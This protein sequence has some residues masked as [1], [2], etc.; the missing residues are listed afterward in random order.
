MPGAR[1]P[2]AGG[3]AILLLNRQGHLSAPHVPLLAAVALLLGGGGAWAQHPS[4][5]GADW[6]LHALGVTTPRRLAAL[7]AE[8]RRPVTIAI[9][10]QG[11]VSQSLLEPV[12]VA[13]NTLEYRQWPEGQAPDPGTDTHDTQA[14]RVILDLTLKLNLTVRLLVYHAAESD[15]SEAQ[16]LA[17]AGAEADIVT[18]YQS[19]WGDVSSL[20]ESIRRSR[21]ALFISP[22]VEVGDTPTSACL[23]AYAAKPWAE[24]LAHFVT[25]IPLARTAPGVLLTPLSRPEQD[26]EVVNFIAPSYYASGAGGTCPSAEVAA[27]VAAYAI[28]ASRDRPSPRDVVAL[29]GETSLVDRAALTSVPEFTEAAVAAIEQQ[30]T[31]LASPPEGTPRKLDARGILN[32]WALHQALARPALEGRTAA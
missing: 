16:A 6:E 21:R 9:V 23:Q 28:A 12:L 11:G 10:G 15:E 19:F 1:P 2:T 22:Y 14:A 20:G 5:T 7:R 29:L 26:S 27:A 31:A 17:R 3:I 25:V 30:I 8:V 18:L 24:G 32:L 4:L 13:G